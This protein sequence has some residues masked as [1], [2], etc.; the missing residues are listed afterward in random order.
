MDEGVV[1]A[2]AAEVVDDIEPRRP[3]PSARA[4]QV[5][6]CLNYRDS[7]RIVICR[8]ENE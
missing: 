2:E 1:G 7:N 8:E 4:P 3:A 5:E 6:R